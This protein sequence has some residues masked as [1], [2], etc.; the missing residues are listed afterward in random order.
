MASFDFVVGR[1]FRRS[2][3]SDYAE[4]RRCADSESWKGVLVLAGSI[5]E[6]LLI[7][8]LVHTP[9]AMPA[10]KDPL[11]YDLGQAVAQCKTSGILS[12]RTADLCSV[13]RSYRNLIHPGRV[14]RLEEKEPDVKTATIA[15]AL[16]DVIQGEI[17]KARR[18][19][20]GLTAEQVLSKVRRDEAALTILPHLL[21]DVPEQER[22]RL[23]QSV[24]PEAYFTLPELEDGFGGLDHDTRSRLS[25]AFRL[26]WDSVAPGVKQQIAG[27]F[28]RILRS[29]DGSRVRDYSRAFVRPE[30]LDSV[31][32]QH[33]VMVK[34][35][36][37]A[38][39]GNLHDLESLQMNEG[40][41]SYLEASDV[42][43]W[44]DPAVR[45]VTARSSTEVLKASVRR[46]VRD[47]C[48]RARRD[49]EG[50]VGGRLEE[51]ISTFEQSD[52][53]G[54]FE[55]VEVLKELKAELFEIPF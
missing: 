4:M 21:D 20:A 37:L 5:V 38:R 16:V 42:P 28:V 29:E 36:L 31:A 40:I 30:D 33:R 13:V 47:E 12:Q 7:D 35:H 39:V 15:M 3:T 24:L 46:F 22:E 50:A 18:L 27:E 52:A 54:A 23:L 6:A 14:V 34:E 19:S 41:G 44:L 45:T 17:A 1:E 8:Y 2:L 25:A 10:G 53:A 51:W 55:R 26:I 9:S 43:R 11:T 49:V 48:F 32:D